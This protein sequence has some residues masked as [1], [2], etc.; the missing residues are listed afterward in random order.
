MK[1]LFVTYCFDSSLGQAM[2]GV[3]KRALRLTLELH[4]RGHEI[5]FFCTGRELFHDS[6]TEKAERCMQ[7]IDIP[8]FKPEYEG[9]EK[10]R[11]IYLS[12]LSEIKP[13][14]VVIGEAP[15]VG[16]LLETTLS[17]AELDIPIVCLDNAYQPYFVQMFWEN[18][19]PMFDGIILNGPSSL[20]WKDAP[21]QLLQVP[22]F[23]EA[24]VEEAEDLLKDLFGQ[25]PA[26]P[27]TVLAYDLNVARMATSLFQE[28]SDPSLSLVYIGSD[29]QKIQEIQEQLPAQIRS[30]SRV[31]Q[32]PSEPA[33]FGL[34]KLS[35]FA[36][37][38][39]AYMQVTECLSLGT[40]VIGYFYP[41][42]FPLSFL[43][44]EIRRFV[45]ATDKPGANQEMVAIAK[46][47]L[48]V[49]PEELLSVHNGELNSLSKAADFLEDLPRL[50]HQE[51]TVN[52]A[53]LGFTKKRVRAALGQL[54]HTIKEQIEVHQIRSTRLR[55]LKNY[56]SIYSV[57]CDYS[58][59]GEQRYAR[60][61]GH[62][63]PTFIQ[64]ILEIK[65]LMYGKSRRQFLFFSPSSR[66]LIELDMGVEILPS[67][68]IQQ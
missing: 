53:Q 33:L 24:S 49:K 3:Y 46:K 42:Y 35:K 22:P 48:N 62:T 7:F 44:D 1:L 19:G 11:E 50:R 23:L 52:A 64:A 66:I 17:A 37:T 38:K 47:Y 51:K 29:I 60:L 41:G 45:Y 5:V 14:I 25:L 56:H 18:H 43:P 59:G 31:I 30:Q 8:F 55:F 12:T 9:A 58:V 4:E 2:I 32:P 13:D 61:W 28:L 39:C 15:M 54:D 21:P 16:P 57:L 65:A 40:P 27:I 26:R 63:F 36:L 10:N 67:Y 6:L 34:I 68:L 20:H